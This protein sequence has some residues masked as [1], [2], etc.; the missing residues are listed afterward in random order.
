MRNQQRVAEVQT[1][2]FKLPSSLTKFEKE[3]NGELIIDSGMALIVLPTS[4][5][6]KVLKQ[7]QVHFLVQQ[8]LL[9]MKPS[10]GWTSGYKLTTAHC[11]GSF[12]VMP[13]FSLHSLH[14]KRNAMM[15]LPTE[16]YMFIMSNMNDATTT[17]T[18][19]TVVKCLIIM[20]KWR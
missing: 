13:T 12:L 5:H 19:A 20:R 10:Q 14:S 7:A 8:V 17:T 1:S 11:N 18:I 15:T 9:S 2:K 3:K 16:N 4:L 6:R